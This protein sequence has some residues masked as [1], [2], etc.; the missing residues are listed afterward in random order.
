MSPPIRRGTEH[1]VVTTDQ[2]ELAGLRVMASVGV[3]PEERSR[4]QPL[5]LALVLTADLAPAGASDALADT[6]DYGAVADAVVAAC[7]QRHYDLLERLAQ[8]VADAAL[9]EGRS[10][11]E[12]GARVAEVTVTVRKLRPPVAHDLAL[13]GVRI[14]RR[15]AVS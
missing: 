5:E 7:A 13:A 6:V 14:T 1:G 4:R 2:I 8:V 11:G 9:S 12:A 3:L 10:D 15:G